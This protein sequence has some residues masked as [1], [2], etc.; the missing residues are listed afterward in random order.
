MAKP[1]GSQTS[2]IKLERK[3]KKTSDGQGLTYCS[4]II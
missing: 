2:T 4:Y 3:P 1:K